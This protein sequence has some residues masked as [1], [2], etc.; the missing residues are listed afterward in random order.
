MSDAGS[1]PPWRR[2]EMPRAALHARLAWRGHGDWPLKD[3]VM[4][5]GVMVSMM[6]SLRCTCS[7]TTDASSVARRHVSA[8]LG[9]SSTS[10]HSMCMMV[11]GRWRRIV[12]DEDEDGPPSLPPPPFAS[13]SKLCP[14]PSPPR[15][16]K[17]SS[18]S[19]SPS[20][21]ASP[22]RISSSPAEATRAAGRY[23]RSRVKARIHSCAAAMV[24]SADS[25]PPPPRRPAAPPDAASSS[26]A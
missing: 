1:F 8:T 15:T 3:A 25:L 20:A 16:L 22:S 5:H 19:S 10:M 26:A 12:V 11:H 21:S 7:T 6:P 17:G 14:T 18:A 23:G 2:A 24:G 13:R 9:A 4:A